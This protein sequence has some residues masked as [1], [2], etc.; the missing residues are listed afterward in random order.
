VLWSAA[1]GDAALT[2]WPG[3]DRVNQGEREL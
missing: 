1:V 3:A 2:P